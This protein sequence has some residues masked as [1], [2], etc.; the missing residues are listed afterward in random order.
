[1]KSVFFI[2]SYLRE[3]DRRRA[4]RSKL[5]ESSTILTR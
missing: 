4:G 2:V 3:E 1:M 5:N